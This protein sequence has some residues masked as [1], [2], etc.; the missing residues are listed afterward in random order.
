MT[1]E[2]FAALLAP[3]LQAI[4]RFIRGRVRAHDQADDILQQTLLHAFVH[5]DQLRTE[6]KFKSWLWTIAFNE[7]R[8]L[9][10]ANRVCVSIDEF[11]HFE[12]PDQTPS[13]LVQCEQIERTQRVRAGLARLNDRDRTAIRLADLNELTTAEAADTLAVSQVAFKS[14]LFRARKRLEHSLRRAA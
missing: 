3:H 2:T 7:I 4:R 13:P 11:A 1:R 8:M 5:R 9:R 14:T 10:R 6:G 12:L